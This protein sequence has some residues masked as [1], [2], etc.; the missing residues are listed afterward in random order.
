MGESVSYSRQC[1][2]SCDSEKSHETL[3]KE[4]RFWPIS[5]QKKV[6]YIFVGGAYAT[7]ISL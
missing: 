1:L 3:V 6:W 2:K 5:H 4:L 7:D